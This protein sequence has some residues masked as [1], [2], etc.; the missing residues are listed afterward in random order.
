MRIKM[1]LLAL[2]IIGLLSSPSL[3]NTFTVGE[4]ALK[5]AKTVN[6]NVNNEA[7][8]MKAL[9]EK[10]LIDRD[11]NPDLQLTEKII[12]DIL[13]R[14]GINSTTTAPTNALDETAADAVIES[15]SGSLSAGSSDS[16]SSQETRGEDDEVNNNGKKRR[17]KGQLPNSNANPNA[18]FSN[19]DEG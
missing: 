19:R 15:L 13:L 14:A 10:N 11:L 2:L 6:K 16:S 17:P 3:T 12:V 1:I 4:F 7:D 9:A 5:Y 18:F 8:A